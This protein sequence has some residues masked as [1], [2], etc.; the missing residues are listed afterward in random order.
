MKILRQKTCCAFLLLSL[1]SLPVYGQ[2]GSE[3]TPPYKLTEIK[4]RPYDQTTD[5][6]RNDIRND[7]DDLWNELDLSVLMT[8]EISGKAGSYSSGR[9]VEII[10]YEGNRVILKRVVGLGVLSESAGKYYV[11]VWLYGPFCRQVTVKA[12]LI[13]QRQTSSLQRKVNFGCGE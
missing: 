3:V 11:P 10:A 4:I 7:K 9:K 5:S 1:L 8:I 13:G 6:L 2:S 12:K